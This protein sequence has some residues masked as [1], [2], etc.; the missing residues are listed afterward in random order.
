MLDRQF[1]SD[2]L[3]NKIGSTPSEIVHLA[4]HGQFSSDAE[5]T[6]LLAWDRKI[7]VKELDELLGARN[8]QREKPIELLI[9]SACETAKGD[10]RAALGIA[11][12]A[13]RSGARSTIATLWAV[14]DDSTALIMEQLYSQ[15][16]QPG[17]SRAEALRNAQLSLLKDSQFVKPY[18]WAGFVL[19]GNWL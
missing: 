14:Q 18:Y 1:T 15:L 6:F 12:V 7:N 10:D 13:L 4:T 11:G 8:R 9:L 3:R 2:A 5:E 16:N 19:I 17:I